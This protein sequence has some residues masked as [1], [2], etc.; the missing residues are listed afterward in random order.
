MPGTKRKRT[1]LSLN[2][3][4]KLIKSSD[5]KPVRKI[6]DEF[7]IGKSAVSNILR[8]KEAILNEFNEAENVDRKRSSGQSQYKD[9]NKVVLAWFTRVRSQNIPVSGPLLQEK[10]CEFAK[11]LGLDNFKA[12]NGWLDRFKNNNSIKC[13]T[14]SGEGASV[15]NATVTD[16]TQKLNTITEGYEPRNI[17]NMDETGL[18]FRAIPDKTLNVKGQDCKGGK[19]AK[20]RLTVVMCANMAGDIEKPVVIG[21]SAKPHCFRN[22]DISQL[23]IVWKHNKK[24]WM[25]T[26][27]FLDWLKTFDKKMHKENRKVLLF[28]DN[29]PTHPKGFDTDNVKIVFLPANTTSHLQ[30]MDQGV[31]QNLKILYRKRVLRETLRILDGAEQNAASVS[32][33]ISVLDACL[34]IDSSVQEIKPAT[35]TKCFA[36]CGFHVTVNESDA[37][38]LT[39]EELQPMID[40]LAANFDVVGAEPFANIDTDAPANEELDDDWESKLVEELRANYQDTCNSNDVI[41]DITKDGPAVEEPPTSDLDEPPELQPEL[42]LSDANKLIEQAL[43]FS[44]SRNMSDLSDLLHKARD[45]MAE[46]I[47]FARLNARQQ[48]V[49]DFF[50]PI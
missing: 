24:A 10:A 18:F 9:L 25:T 7:G 50:K 28:L 47:A 36:K 16:W 38:L 26:E 29:A 3:K 4:V 34:W 6:A 46:Q 49:T 33:K 43:Q 8:Q 48:T 17:Y 37:T 13:Q 32:S 1:D 21:R 45:L 5:G 42:K 15:D 19:K 44:E 23:P 14:L 12:S 31:I 35:V 22:R 40:T 41:D 20:D 27:L 39:S 11:Q 2:D 30:P